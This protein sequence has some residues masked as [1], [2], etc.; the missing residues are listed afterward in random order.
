MINADW[1]IKAGDTEPAFSQQLNYAD[2]TP[3][4]LTGAT[5]AL[6]IRA[7]GSTTS[8]TLSGATSIGS[9]SIAGIVTYTPTS[10]DTSSPGSYV[11]SWVVTFSGGQQMSFPTEGYL[12]IEIEDSITA[13]ADLQLVDLT[14][15]KNKLNITT[16][17]R[18][19]DQKLTGWIKAAT[20]LIENMAGPIIPRTYDEWHDGGETY[21]MLRRR[22]STAFGTSPL[23]TLVACSE[24]SG[25]IEWPLS[26]V[27]SPDQ[28]QLYSVMLDSRLGRVVRRTAGGGIQAFPNAP[29]SVHVVYQAGQASIP[30][31]VQEAA[32][33]LIRENYESTQPVG[34]GSQTLADLQDASAPSMRSGWYVSPGVRALL[35]PN[36]RHPSIA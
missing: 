14:D 3:V 29:Q 20:A 8:Q 18:S 6:A 21:I 33:E 4:D 15:L 34:S 17:D 28:G 19:R 13:S 22:P 31:N 12:S 23:L 32:L 16:S 5:V 2:N 7:V 1:T 36:R 9:P 35:S 30:W 27:A 10:A 24:Y 25:P 26:I 11:G